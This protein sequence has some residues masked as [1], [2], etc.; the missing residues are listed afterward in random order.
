MLS[1]DGEVE[2]DGADGRALLPLST[3]FGLYSAAVA[4]GEDPG[5]P[6]LELLAVE[7]RR[8]LLFSCSRPAARAGDHALPANLQGLWNDSNTPPWGG[9]FHSNINL[10][11]NY[12]PTEVLGLPDSH[13]PL[14]SW[15][16]EVAEPSRAATRNAFG[17][18]TPGWMARTSQS[19]FGGNAWE[20]N[21][22]AHA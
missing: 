21:T 14:F 8:Y 4:A 6:D 12:W 19:A 9:D 7:Y 22:V 17:E 15:L 20:W 11:M 1:T 5:D 18:D 16:R 2:A 13:L 10:Q 3:G